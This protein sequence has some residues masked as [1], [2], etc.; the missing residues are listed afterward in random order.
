MV[1]RLCG[2]SNG[3]VITTDKLKEFSKLV[4]VPIKGRGPE[5]EE[6]EIGDEMLAIYDLSRARIEKPEDTYRDSHRPGT[7]ALFE[8]FYRAYEEWKQTYG[9]IDFTDMLQKYLDKPVSHGISVFIIDEAQDLSPLQW[10]VIDEMSKWANHII[11]SGDDDQSLFFWGGADPRGMINF[12]EKYGAKRKILEQS[13]RIP[14]TV[15]ALADKVISTI[16]DRVEKVYKPRDEEGT[17]QRHSTFLTAPL[18]GDVLILFR[19]HAIRKEMEEII[20]DHALPYKVRSGMPGLLD[21][22]YATA[23]RKWKRLVDEGSLSTRDTSL[24]RRCAWPNIVQMLDDKEF[25]KLSKMD[26]QSALKIPYW[27]VEYYTRVDFDAE[28]KIEMSSI[29]GAKGHEAD[30]VILNTGMTQR[31]VE[32]AIKDPDSEA[33]VWYVGVTRAKHNLHIVEGESGYVL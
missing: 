21:N 7:F 27:M 1:Y 22:R 5:N 20:I 25:D 4:H 23:I 26:W 10:K 17:V 30:T 3:Q 33:R 6:V 13:W 24:I 2:V 16:T 15:H 8:K 28:P 9:Y 14:L 19:N 32:S 12:E 29:H 31:T 18:D 11:I